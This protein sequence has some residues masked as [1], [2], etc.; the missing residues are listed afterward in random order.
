MLRYGIIA[1]YGV[2]SILY[3][4][5]IYPEE[6]FTRTQKYG[7]TLL[8]TADEKLKAYLEQASVL[9]TT[10]S[11]EVKILITESHHCIGVIKVHATYFVWYFFPIGALSSQML[12]ELIDGSET[13]CRSQKCRHK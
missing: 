11:P 8:V 2:N 3:Q 6:S 13:G 10:C 12:V 4:R 9:V 7:L 1:D 5:G